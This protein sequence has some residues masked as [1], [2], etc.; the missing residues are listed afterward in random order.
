LIR[1]YPGSFMLGSDVVGS[2]AT[3][4]RELNRYQPLLDTISKDP[5][6]KVR[7]KLA[8]DN[9]VILMTDLG[10]RRLA[11]MVRE[12][13]V[14]GTAAVAT[15]MILKSD[16]EFDERSH[17]GAPRRSFMRENRSLDSRATD[18]SRDRQSMT[19]P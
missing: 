2:G 1:K 7:R 15:G 19:T 8:R 12:G 13:V 3:I 11:K 9:F 10:R 6:D 14:A 4:G 5:S 17:T 16:Y 18:R